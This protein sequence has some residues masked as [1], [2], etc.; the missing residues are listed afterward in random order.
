MSKLFCD[1][2]TDEEKSNFFLSG[3][4]VETGII[5]PAI[6]NEVSMAFH[7]CFEFEKQLAAAIA[8]CKAKDMALERI[9]SINLAEYLLPED[10]AFR[11]LQAR[12]AL[13]IQPDDAALRAWLGEPVAYL[14]QH[15]DTGLTTA[16]EPQQLEWG[17][18]NKN[19][20]HINCGPLYRPKGLK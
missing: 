2:K 14:F 9:A 17:F 5:A 16:V 3:Q 11:V 20:R 13:A 12:K 15:E 8:A 18:E 1:C 6:S 4:G 7:R 10:F 19:P